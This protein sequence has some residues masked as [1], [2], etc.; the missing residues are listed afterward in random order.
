MSYYPWIRRILAI[1]QSANL[2]PVN[3]PQSVQAVSVGNPGAL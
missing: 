3:A 2:S 1:H